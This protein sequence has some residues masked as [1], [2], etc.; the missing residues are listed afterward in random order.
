MRLAR[1]EVLVGTHPHRPKALQR[2]TPF[3]RRM[4]VVPNRAFPQLLPAA[5]FVLFCVDIFTETVVDDVVRHDKV[6]L[7]FVR[8]HWLA[9]NMK[10]SN[11]DGEKVSD[12]R[13]REVGKRLQLN[14]FLSQGGFSQ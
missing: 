9:D 12:Y 1:E 4:S 6:E 14:Y 13:L 3:R 5:G 10:Q 2:R 8:A 11:I 7:V